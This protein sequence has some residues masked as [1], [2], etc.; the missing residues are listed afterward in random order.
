MLVKYECNVEFQYFVIFSICFAYYSD[1]Y[2]VIITEFL[3][4]FS[5]ILLA[6][7]PVIISCGFLAKQFYSGQSLSNNR[8]CFTIFTNN[9]SSVQT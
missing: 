3:I 7:I 5:T 2:M 9:N 8:K 1:V 4:N 6:D